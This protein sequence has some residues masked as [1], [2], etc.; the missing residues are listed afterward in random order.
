VHVYEERKP[1]LI[2][3]F[4]RI[5]L[6]I[7]YIDH[8]Q[9]HGVKARRLELHYRPQPRGGVIVVHGT[10]IDRLSIERESFI[11]VLKQ[12]DTCKARGIVEESDIC[13]DPFT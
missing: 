13:L 5:V 7:T 1:V 10:W 4:A 8:M 2:L 9:V 6:S 3:V 11:A 12:I